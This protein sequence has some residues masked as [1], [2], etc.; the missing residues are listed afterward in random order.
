MSN[1]S[2]SEAIAFIN[3]EIVPLYAGQLTQ[4]L[5]DD[6]VSGGRQSREFFKNY[7]EIKDGITAGYD[8]IRTIYGAERLLGEISIV[9]GIAVR[10][11][12]VS[13]VA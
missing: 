6:A 12:S 11:S 1:L 10:N 7:P 5:F 13:A 2:I 3:S 9:N 8:R 4:Q